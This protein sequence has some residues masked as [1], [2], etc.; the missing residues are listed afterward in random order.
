MKNAVVCI[1]Y[2]SIVVTVFSL[3]RQCHDI[4]NWKN[5]IVPALSFPSS[6]W[7]WRKRNFW[8]LRFLKK[9]VVLSIVA[10]QS[11]LVFVFWFMVFWIQFVL[12]SPGPGMRISIFYMI[13]WTGMFRSSLR[14]LI[15]ESSFIFDYF[16]WLKEYTAACFYSCAK[17]LDSFLI[18]L[19]FNELWTVYFHFSC[20]FC[21]RSAFYFIL[22]NLCFESICHS[23]WCFAILEWWWVVFKIFLFQIFKF[24]F[25][26]ILF[27]NLIWLFYSQVCCKEE[28]RFVNLCSMETAYKMYNFQR[29]LDNLLDRKTTP[30]R[31]Y[32][33]LK[34]LHSQGCV[35]H[36]Q[37]DIKKEHDEVSARVRE[38][39]RDL[40]QAIFSEPLVL[41]SGIDNALSNMFCSFDQDSDFQFL[42]AKMRWHS[43]KIFALLA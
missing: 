34:K 20:L 39:Q 40:V 33:G 38:Y 12:F 17:F 9:G 18:V 32:F 16:L 41:L 30:K 10:F 2:V 4:W 6:I 14:L 15:L 36:I 11:Q 23:L 19:F 27:L 24:S 7:F 31:R 42:F 43:K 35:L 13:N 29:K 25:F 37:T 5:F 1:F 28:E 22:L 26:C 8:F 3:H 21:F